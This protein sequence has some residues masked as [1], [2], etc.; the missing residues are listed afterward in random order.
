M[1]NKMRIISATIFFGGIWGIIEATLGYVLHIIPGLSLYMS[2]AVL[3]SFASFILY[4]AYKVTD[5][6][7]A[8]LGVGFIAAAIKSIDFLLPIASPFKVINPM[9]SIIMESLMVVAVIRMLTKDSLTSKASALAIAS[10][11]WRVL[12]FA[13]MGIQF[14]TSGFVYL[15]STSQYL[16]FFG[17]YAFGSALF[18][19]G[20][21]YLDTLLSKKETSIK[22]N[23]FQP[24]FS[25]LSVLLALVLTL[26]L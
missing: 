2:G 1:K 4:R 16:E 19:L 11:G 14:L 17:I 10:V 9:L 24:V 23:L 26:A 21:V 15:Q 12:Y 6:R 13:Y 8:L 22:F 7:W 5:S 25:L 18:G 20:L 3:F